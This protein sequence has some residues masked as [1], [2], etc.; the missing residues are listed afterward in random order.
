MT[1][2]P[3]NHL[4]V[5]KDKCPSRSQ[6][7]NGVVNTLQTQTG[8]M[9]IWDPSTPLREVSDLSHDTSTSATSSVT[10]TATSSTTCSTT[11]ESATPYSTMRA[12]SY[13]SHTFPPRTASTSPRPSDNE[14][15]NLLPSESKTDMAV[16]PW[17]EHLMRWEDFEHWRLKMLIEPWHAHDYPCF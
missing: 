6:T 9:K 3:R 2:P 4:S 7:Q 12:W 14:S 16:G 5:N 13:F 11:T 10:S 1:L 8:R 17:F 15:A